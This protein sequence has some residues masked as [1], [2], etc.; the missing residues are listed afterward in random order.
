MEAE[1][2]LVNRRKHERVSIERVLYLEVVARGSRSEADNRILRCETVDISV[3]GLCLRVPERI[4]PGAMLNI[5]APLDDWKSELHLVA[6]SK[7]LRPSDDGSGYWLGVELSDSSKEDM[8]AWF[9]IVYRLRGNPG[10]GT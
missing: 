3:G 5:A 6:E 7:W 10:E 1:E 2:L 8:E 4:E 9:K